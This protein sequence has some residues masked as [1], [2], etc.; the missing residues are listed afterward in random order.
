MSWN[1]SKVLEEMQR[2]NAKGANLNLN[3]CGLWSPGQHLIRKPISY[4]WCKYTRQENFGKSTIWSHIQKCHLKLNC[5]EKKRHHIKLVKREHWCSWAQ[6]YLGWTIIYWKFVLWSNLSFFD[7]CTEWSRWR[8]DIRNRSA[9]LCYGWGRCQCP[10]QNSL[11][12]LWRHHH[13]KTYT[14]IWHA[15]V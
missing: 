11:E 13:A 15:D 12:I 4:S 9:W 5:W 3:T 7:T 14:E 10:S 2:I 1:N 8:T 6:R